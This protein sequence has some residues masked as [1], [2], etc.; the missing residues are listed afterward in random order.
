MLFCTLWTKTVAEFCVRMF[1]DIVLQRFPII[2]LVANS[3]TE[4]ANWQ[5]TSQHSD[6]FQKR[7][8]L[9][10]IADEKNKK[11][12]NNNINYCPNH[13]KES[14]ENQELSITNKIHHDLTLAPQIIKFYNRENK[15]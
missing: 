3:L 12:E 15:V 13:S 8:P 1:S 5:K 2:V 9:F 11:R 14:S 10:F 4:T 7:L 6:F